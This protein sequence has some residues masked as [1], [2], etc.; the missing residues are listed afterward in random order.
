[1]NTLVMIRDDGCA[2]LPAILCVFEGRN[3]QLNGGENPKCHIPKV[4][5]RLYASPLAFILSGK[6]LLMMAV[7]L[8]N[9]LCACHLLIKYWEGSDTGQQCCFFPH[10]FSLCKA[11]I[12][13]HVND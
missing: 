6:S 5:E 9:Q 10:Y 1:M 13:Y 3:C 12:N 4:Q 7:Y 11:S 2:E 8:L